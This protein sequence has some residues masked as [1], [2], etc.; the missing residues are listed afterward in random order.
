MS[1]IPHD[2]H[3][4]SDAAESCAGLGRNFHPLNQTS[5]C[6]LEKERNIQRMKKRMKENDVPVVTV[7]QKYKKCKPLAFHPDGIYWNSK[8]R[9]CYEDLV[10]K[11]GSKGIVRSDSS[12]NEQYSCYRPVFSNSIPRVVG[13]RKI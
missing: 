13:W 6:F 8:T 10:P 3:T 12:E 1:R 4:A 11:S 2:S 9:T 5:L 7:S